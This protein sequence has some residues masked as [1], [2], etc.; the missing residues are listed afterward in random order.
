MVL[1]ESGLNSEQVSL[2]KPIYIEKW[3]LVMKQVVLIVRVVLILSG[4]Y[5]ETLLNK[6]T[7]N[8][9]LVKLSQNV[10]ENHH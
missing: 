1:V 9:I 10:K 3:I 7:K 5:N 6:N 4:L 8:A 2:T